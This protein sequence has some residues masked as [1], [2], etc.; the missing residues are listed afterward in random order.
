MAV[1]GGPPPGGGG[2]PPPGGG[3]PAP[4]IAEPGRPLKPRLTV[5]DESLDVSWTAPV[6][7]GATI[8]DY[9][10]RFRIEDT[11][12]NTTGRQPGTWDS[13]PYTGA[14]T[15]TSI[16]SLANGTRY[17]V[18]VRATN[19]AGPGRWSP[20][21]GAAPAGVPLAPGVPTVEAKHESVAVSWVAPDGN[22]AA[23]ADYDVR[24]RACADTNKTC[25]DADDPWGD[26]TD[27]SGE[28]T[29]DKS[30][31]A[32]IT[33]LTN[34]TA[35]QVQVRAANSAGESDWSGSGAATPGAQVPDR[36]ASPAT[37]NA[38]QC[39]RASWTEP[40]AN[41]AAIT[42]YEVQYRIRSGGAWPA[43][44]TFHTATTATSTM[45]CGPSGNSQGQ[46]VQGAADRLP[47]E[48]AALSNGPT[49]ASGWT[50]QVGTTQVQVRAVN[51]VGSGGWSA[52]PP[53]AP[54]APDLAAGHRHIGVSWDAPVANGA[55][56][57]DY[58]VRYR[59]CT[60]TDGDSSVNTC[61]TDPT[62]G[63]WRNRSGETSSDTATSATITNLTNGTAFQVQVRAANS[64]GESG[65]SASAGATPAS[66]EPDP[67][68]APTLGLKDQSLEVTWRATA[69][70]G[71]A[72]TG[73]DVQYRD[74]TATDPTCASNPTWGNWASHTHTG[75]GTSTTIGSLTNGT[76][77]EVR[78]RATTG[79]G[80][81]GWSASSNGTPSSTQDVQ[82][83]PPNA[84]AVPTVEAGNQTLMVSWTAPA[85]NGSPITGYSVRYRITDTDDDTSG[86]QP[87]SWTYRN[88]P[89]A[90]TTATVIGSLTNDVGYDMQVLA[91]SANGDSLW[92]ESA[93]GT[94]AAQK[95]DKPAAPMLTVWNQRLRVTWTPPASNGSVIIDYD[96]QYRACTLSTDLACSNSKTATW[97]TN[98]TDRGG[99]TTPD[100]ATATAVSGLTNETAYQV[101]VRAANSV[102]ESGWSDE[103]IA[104]PTAQP[105]QTPAAPTVTPKNQSLDVSWTAPADNGASVTGYDVQYRACTATPKTCATN[106]TWGNWNSH[107]H[108]GTGTSTTITGLTNETAYQVQIQAT[109]SVGDSPWSASGTGTP[110][111]QKPDAPDAPT[112]TVKNQSL[113]VSWTAPA[114]NGA[115]ITDYDVQYRACTATNGD[116]AVLTCA[117]NPT[118]GSWK[119]HTHT[120]IGTTATIGSL[121]NETAYQVQVQATNSVGDSPWSQESA[122]AAPTP[123]K[124]DAPDAPTVTVSNQSLD[125]SWT[126][127]AN[128]GA[129]ITDYDMQHRACTATP[130]TCTT[131][132]TWGSWTSHTH[133][134]T[135]TSTTIPSLTNGTAYQVQ[136]QATNSV[137]DSPWSTSATATPT[138]QKPDAPAAPTVTVR[139]QS[140]GVSWT[141][142]ANNGASITD[143]DVQYRTCTKSA[144]LTC[145]SDPTWG[146]WNNRSGETTG[147]TGTSV[148]ITGLTNETAY[149]VRVRAGNS[150]GDSPW[151]Q[152]SAMATPT[153]QV[154]DPP[155]AP[156]LTH[157]DQSLEVS[158][159]EPADNGANITDYDVQYR[160]CTL[161]TDL[162]CADSSTAT[163]ESTWTDRTGET[164]SDTSR[165]VTVSGLTNGTAYQVQVRAANS[166]GE[167]EWSTSAD[168]YPST[169]PGKP[170]APTLS[171]EDQGL[172]V[173]WSAPS[174]DGGADITGYK[175][176]RCSS[177]C[178][179][180]SNWTVKTL[181]GTGTTTDLTGLT[182]GTAYQVRV[183]AVNRSGTGSWSDT[184][185]ETPADEPDAPGAPTV[186]VWNQSLNVS[187][188]APADNGATISDYDVQYRACTATD[189]DTA[190]L[191]C[192]TNPTWGTWTDRTGET[193]SDTTTSVT[194]SSLTNDTAYQ[195]Q[196]RAANSVGESTWSTATK[197]TPTPQKPD[198][199]AAATLTHGNTS[200]TVSWTAPADN[201]ASISDYDVQYRAC[202]LSTDLTCSNSS[203]ATWGSWT[204]RTG[205]T[206]SD[207]TRSVT[208]SNLTNGTAYQVQVRAANS[209]GEGAWS[210]SADEYP[211][212]VPGK[213]TAPTLTVKDQSLG[214]SWSAP[215]SNGGAAVTGYKVGSCS[216]SCSSDASWT[217]KTL[218]GTGTTTDLTG[219][220]NGTAY[221]VRVAA[222]NRSGTGS[223]SD[224]ATKTPADEPDAPSAPTVTVWNQQL[225]VSWTAPTNNGAAITDYDVQYQACTATDGDTAVLTCATNPTWGTWTDRTGETTTDTTTSATLSSLTNDTAYQVQVRAANS[226]GE[227]TWSTATKATPTAQKPDAPA[228][229][230][231]THGAAS[232]SVSW[233]A[234][235]NNGASISDYDVQYRACTLS[236]DLT[237]SDSNTATW[238]SW[239]DRSGETTSDTSRSVTL[240]GLTN[241]TAYQV[242]VR[243]A[244]SVGES[245]WSTSADEYPSTVPG[246]PA[247]PTLSVKHQALGVSWSAPSSNGGAAITG[248]KVGRCSASCSSDTSWTVKT[249]TTTGT[250]TDLTGLTNGTSY[251][252]R[253]AAVNRSGTG[254][255][256]DTTTA[257]PAKVPDAPSAPTLTKGARQLSV[258]WSAPADNGEEITDYD[259]R[260]C[261]N[262]TGCD[263]DS[264]WTSLSGAADPGTSTTA[265]ISNLTNGTTYQVQVRATNSVGD[266]AWSLSSSA[267]PED[268]PAQPAAPTLTYSNT[269]LG[270]SWTAPADNGQEISDYD[271]QYRACTYSTDLTC[272]SSST[273]TW[274]NWTDRTGETSSDTSTSVTLSGLTNGTAY[275]VQVRAANSVG[276]S[277]WST[278]ASE[279]PSTVPGKPAAPTLSVKDQGLGVSWSAPSSTGGAAVTGFKV[280]RC[281][282]NCGSDASWTVKTLTTAGTTTDLT[283]LTNGTAY[284][285]RVAAVNRSG[286]SAW[287]DTTTATP[288]KAPDTP[289]APTLTVKNESLDVSWTA[290][291]DNG[292]SISDYD[293]Q[294]RACTLSTDLT[295]SDSNTAT[296]GSW[297]DRTGETNGDT[298]TSVTI[299]SLTNETAYQVRVR[300]ANSVG[301]STWSTP[302]AKATP[303][304]QKPDKPAAPTLSHGNA[305]LSVSWSAPANNG[306]SIT[307]YDVQYRACT[308]STDLTCSD[309]STA[310]WGNW[311]DRTGE[312]TS[313]TT[314]SATLSGLT[315]GTAYQVQVRA[316]NSVGESRWSASASEYPSTT[317]GKPAAP[318]LTVK[319]VSL[320]VSWSAPSSNGGATITGYKVGRCSSSCSNNSNWTVKTLTGTGT[321]TD[322]TSLTNG[323]A[324]QVRVAAVNRSG[325]SAWSDT[326]TETPADEPDAPGAPTLT[327]WNQQLTVSWTAPTDNGA[328][329]TDYDVQYRA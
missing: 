328:S 126:A 290:P 249:L 85:N 74:C 18:Q 6:E 40:A 193:S 103:A 275:Q 263:A 198:K 280:G 30:T 195:V 99:E 5:Q 96:L 1:V 207:T 44:W 237:C 132:P 243:A 155:A 87:G 178:S 315:N 265:T 300:A 33:S 296:W 181:T 218:T 229:P 254:A 169:T 106:P 22:G 227:S 80:E 12:L 13:H 91:R 186:G 267:A 216:A 25:P 197:A 9:D 209:V 264:E 39:V 4:P 41:G 211:S 291:T 86:D 194:L 231:L 37:T 176:G 46:S 282:A 51:S 174:S 140:L 185:T 205:E 170:A 196:V 272:S 114:D 203:T 109:N 172:G 45:I 15:S 104:I 234:P 17:Q 183:A 128:N 268:E 276:E 180:D 162:T 239:T 20:S 153:P 221:Q 164:T 171:V 199:P 224:T 324:Y 93:T 10:L 56:I 274:G 252:V 19:S 60:A 7:N 255:W 88:H 327:V 184:A 238:G 156:T 329:I 241:G 160:A 66:S 257:T 190:V 150:V 289:A 277:D 166:V 235:T 159:T 200:L 123:Q 245:G 210:V 24:Y 35:Y 299:G 138:P 269:S 70:N 84:P 294:Y 108:A 8:T 230:T 62:W 314:T 308:Y 298:T 292:A 141:A 42:T 322:L 97:E 302:S 82:I 65:W 154:P 54:A 319:D 3:P 312:T 253:V 115:N 89:D 151:S 139:N 28:T 107:T 111:P 125:L 284:Q 90:S 48:Y 262:S 121:T 173:S 117:T 11:D 145:A 279:Y 120:G 113:G 152:E 144:D 281:S 208:L 187:W 261:V 204:D 179:N 94:P 83:P 158:W 14:G 307:D 248:Y 59:A 244:N 191:S 68:G 23:I 323:T 250:T 58:D 71:V 55:A 137:G 266:G 52:Q 119:S 130:K 318:T 232:L 73:Y 256:S 189:G 136:I 288:A 38:G 309:S 233:T 223:W 36:V 165:S 133:T 112:L 61:A 67:P 47:A 143:Y 297:T 57:S 21:A 146:A 177:S 43:N 147:D 242:Q 49:A 148:T 27:R 316:A 301:E 228:A 225:T 222:V 236:T 326:T 102:G 273:A 149:Q 317:P 313:D 124:P 283:S 215:S 167:S 32:T 287:S 303:T 226:V 163:W 122:K 168:E 95:P 260:Y 118:W 161:S 202:T 16:P 259:V 182:N 285:V 81:S 77:Y 98:W 188:T 304:P 79:T 247:A 320:G 135:G 69:S 110:T 76:A 214:V 278:S 306:A 295:C 134:G 258:S 127:P 271:V 325:D 213:P 286:D 293:V 129:S 157:G 50:V 212:T 26:W 131:N 31:S 75:T 321:T 101:R 240:S 64:E 201:G 2:A 53:D 142:P 206:N 217:V 78:I 246:K 175:V 29:S 192:G 63:S 34:G 305:S 270:V 311:T 72:I 92:S 251:Q 310:T 100:T 220:T 219:L 116:T 105:P